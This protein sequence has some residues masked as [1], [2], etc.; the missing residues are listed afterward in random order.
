MVSL[1][2]YLTPTSHKSSFVNLN[3]LYV[4]RLEVGK[5]AISTETFYS[6]FIPG[7]TILQLILAALEQ[8]PKL[9]MTITKLHGPKIDQ[10]LHG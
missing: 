6:N 8:Y 5:Y 4:L 1:W 10:G 7:R 9:P 3:F 2:S